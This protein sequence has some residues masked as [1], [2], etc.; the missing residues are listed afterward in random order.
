MKGIN[1]LNIRKFVLVFLFI[2][3]S[4]LLLITFNSQREELNNLFIFSFSTLWII[5]S[6]V[7]SRYSFRKPKINFF[8]FV[9]EFY[10]LLITFSLTLLILF[11]LNTF[12]S[13][14]EFLLISN[15]FLIDFAIKQL[16]LSLIFFCSIKILFIKIKRIKKTYFFIGSK[17]TF[18]K[19]KNICK[20]SFQDDLTEVK[21]FEKRGGILNADLIISDKEELDI[22]LKDPFIYS[23]ILEHKKN[24]FTLTDWIEI[25]LQRIPNEFI[26]F[27]KK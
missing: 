7:L 26:D 10:K 6:Y 18:L 24:I 4:S 19:F 21:F 17:E 14:F 20:Q 3:I 27:N 8:F 2:D 11:V 13:I 16:L 1:W 25:Y 15:L 22:L 9:N 12:L 5:F 23:I